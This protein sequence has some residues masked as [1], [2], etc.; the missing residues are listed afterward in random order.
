MILHNPFAVSSTK[1][2]EKQDFT[3][4]HGEFPK[5]VESEDGRYSFNPQEIRQGENGHVYRGF[6]NQLQRPVALKVVDD[7]G[8]DQAVIRVAR[9]LASIEN[10]GVMK[11]QE[12]VFFTLHGYKRI[13]VIYEWLEEPTITE[14]AAP[15]NRF[16][17]E[18]FL[19]VAI[20]LDR[21]HKQG[22][23]HND[24]APD[25][26]VIALN[27]GALRTVLSDWDISNMAS[28]KRT[29]YRNAYASPH[30]VTS[31]VFI[32]EDDN[33]SLLASFYNILSGKVPFRDRSKS[34]DT[35]NKLEQNIHMVQALGLETTRKLD[36]F[37]HKH[38]CD[39]I[40]N[41]CNAEQL[42]L[43]L[44]AILPPDYLDKKSPKATSS[45][46]SSTTPQK[47]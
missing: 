38:L 44:A 22:W 8:N 31:N 21:I 7:Y 15:T 46:P 29:D 39:D 18:A 28:D 11:V 30:A 40:K 27:N 36:E 17:I 19:S 24:V 47:K 13:G 41:L 23:V 2:D 12:I 16:Y 4:R 34:P 25:N 43:E 33:W 26:I 35:Y 45:A 14:F 5:R 3:A 1:F 37:F 32:P 10:P 9:G 6:D 42:I 20:T